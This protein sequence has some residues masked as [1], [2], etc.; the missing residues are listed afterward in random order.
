MPPSIIAFFCVLFIF[1]LFWFDL[2]K[3][4]DSSNALWI[5]LI[6][7]FLAGS[8][9]VSS[10]LNLG[11]PM[12]SE[13]AYLEGSPVDATVFFLLMAIGLLILFGRKLNWGRLFFLN[14]WIVFYYLYC[15]I[16][17]TW[18]DNPFISLKRLI[19]EWGVVIM[20]L[21]ILS[22]KKPYE[23]IGAHI[24][25]PIVSLPCPYRYCLLFIIHVRKN[26]S[27]RWVPNAHRDHSSEK[28]SWDR[29]VCFPEFILSGIFSLTAKRNNMEWKEKHLI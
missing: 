17:I 27:C 19:K 9:Y 29:F 15:L 28:S 25:A 23:S 10:W 6:W 3:S 4:N 26:I 18:A 24:K 13:Q 12:G 1:Y 5:P 21:V 8:R 20:A 7:M 14:K 11:G 2:K 22:E 16:S